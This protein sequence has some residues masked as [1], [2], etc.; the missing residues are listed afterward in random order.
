MTVAAALAACG[1]EN[2]SS[3]IKT[4][5]STDTTTANTTRV[6]SSNSQ[7]AS[8]DEVVTAYL[9]VKNSLAEDNAKEAATAAGGLKDALQKI[10]QTSFTADQHKVYDDL[11]ESV[12]EHAEHI[13]S[14]GDKIAHQREHFDMMSQDMYDLVKAVKPAQPLYQTYC[15]MYN[16]SKGASWLSETK[17]IKNPYMGKKMQTCGEVK[18]EIK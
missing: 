7:T 3:T 15:P 9:K 6:D 4:G 14:N 8:V 5:K 13:S 18:E 12:K 17:K 2:D 10:Q 16:D 11:K 1:N